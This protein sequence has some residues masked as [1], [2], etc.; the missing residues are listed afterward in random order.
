MTKTTETRERPISFSG[1]MICA[2]L[3][4]RKSVTRRIIKPQPNRLRADWIAK[5]CPYG[6]VGSRLWVRETWQQME[7]IGGDIKESIVYRAD[8]EHKYG[9]RPS[10]FMPRWASRITLE[11]TAVHVEQLHQITRG[12]AIQEGAQ[13]HDGGG[14]G[15]SGWRMDY[16]DV[17]NGPVSAFVGLW[18]RLNGKTFPWESNPRVWVVNFRRVK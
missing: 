3:D 12:G 2:I 15:H 6:Q 5:Y 18:D 17:F 10:I 13:Y 1:P 11:I 8:A 14:I 7:H 9:W 4:G 16:S